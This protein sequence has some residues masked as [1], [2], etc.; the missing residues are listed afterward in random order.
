MTITLTETD[1]GRHIAAHVAD[2]I[3]VRLAENAT[4]GY[5]WAVEDLDTDVL[6]LDEAAADYP[7]QTLGSGGEAIFRIRVHAAGRAMLRLQYRRPW[8]GDAGVTKRFAV[9]VESAPA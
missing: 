2:V 6:A 5:R 9:A 3:E 7:R 8:E 1:D 4:T